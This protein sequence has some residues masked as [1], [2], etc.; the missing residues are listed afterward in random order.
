M[1][2]GRDGSNATPGRCPAAT[3]CTPRDGSSPAAASS[4]ST[5]GE[6]PAVIGSGVGRRCELRID[7]SL[8]GGSHLPLEPAVEAARADL[9][10]TILLDLAAV[11]RLEQLV[12]RDPRARAVVRIAD[13]VH[14]VE[15]EHDLLERLVELV[16]G[17]PAELAALARGVVILAQARGN[18]G[19]AVR[20]LP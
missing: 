11:A 12:D 17:D 14:L 6:A 1:M 4:S 5:L 3:S 13:L 2:S 18:L 19:E 8:D 15:C 10:Q 20:I 9:L 7:P 16:R